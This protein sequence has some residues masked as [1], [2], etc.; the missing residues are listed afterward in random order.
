MDINSIIDRLNKELEKL[1]NIKNQNLNVDSFFT[2]NEHFNEN[3]ST[4]D[5]ATP[6]EENINNTCNDSSKDMSDISNVDE[7]I[8]SNIEPDNET[9]SLVNLKE[10]RLFVAQAMFKKSIRISLKSF[11]ISISLSFLNLFI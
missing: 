6:Q 8:S 7:N 5:L 10:R 11:L 9:V 4:D 2:N 1:N 3:F